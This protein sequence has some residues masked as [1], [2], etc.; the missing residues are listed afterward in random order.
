MSL[1]PF[2]SMQNLIFKS[3]PT[4][5]IFIVV[6]HNLNICR[7]TINGPQNALKSPNHSEECDLLTLMTS[8]YLF[9]GASTTLLMTA[10][11]ATF[12][13]DLNFRFCLLLKSALDFS[14]LYVLVGLSDSTKP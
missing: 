10:K 14:C 1:T 13:G 5:A 3:V 11:N 4:V 8:V 7:S 2:N 9:S 12:G 6:N